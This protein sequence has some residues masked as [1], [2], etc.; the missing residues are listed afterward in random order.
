VEVKTLEQDKVPGKKDIK[1]SEPA[2]KWWKTELYGVFDGGEFVHQK[3]EEAF[4]N[5]LNDT[6]GVDTLS[7]L[8]DIGII[9]P[10]AELS[11]ED[12]KK[13]HND[14]LIESFQDWL[15]ENGNKL[16]RPKD[17]KIKIKVKENS[18]KPKKEA[19]DMLIPDLMEIWENNETIVELV[20]GNE[21][22]LVLTLK[23]GETI[24]KASL[25]LGV[26]T[27]KL[28]EL[29]GDVEE[30]LG[31]TPK[32][33]KEKEDFFKLLKSIE[34]DGKKM[35]SEK[36]S[37]KGEVNK[38]I[39]KKYTKTE[40]GENKREIQ[41][42]LNEKNLERY[43]ESKERERF[44]DL[45]YYW[46]AGRIKSIKFG[47]QVNTLKGIIVKIKD[48]EELIL[49]FLAFRKVFD[50]MEPFSE[51]KD[52]NYYGVK[53]TDTGDYITQ[54]TSPHILKDIVGKINLKGKPLGPEVE[55]S[56]IELK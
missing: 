54:K 20:P 34:I 50:G 15:S 14:L 31:K 32:T 3:L 11:E 2:I 7:E 24:K 22:K 49:P 29:G 52:R 18:P 13:M 16:L 19:G 9:D 25:E 5:F 17:K 44:K 53:F 38:N 48:G 36:F 1:K 28:K 10:D 46:E 6:Y 43:V 39:P 35:G 8:D 23:T 30:L 56:F 33:E 51:K 27:K 41:L 42:E 12:E 40:V 37:V 47:Y 45:V 4:C 55:A 21:R 26:L